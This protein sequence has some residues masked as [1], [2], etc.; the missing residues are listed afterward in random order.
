MVFSNHLELGSS[1]LPN[2]VFVSN[3]IY[4]CKRCMNKYCNCTL[5]NATKTCLALILADLG[6]DIWLGNS[7]G[8]RYS[9][10]HVYLNP[11]FRRYWQFSYITLRT[12]IY[13]TCYN[14]I[15]ILFKFGRSGRIRH[16]CYDKLRFDSR[17]SG[18]I[19]LH[20]WFNWRSHDFH[21]LD[22]TSRAQCQNWANGMLFA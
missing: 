22:Q 11:K 18:D 20:S 16:P 9:R 12:Y 6:Y 1:I 13:I 2:A 17:K 19:N 7:R 14:W 10:K 5:N 21:R 15:K 8:N 4:I 3:H